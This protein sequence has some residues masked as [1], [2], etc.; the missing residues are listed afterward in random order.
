[1]SRFN[2]PNH[3]V[4]K[5]ALRGYN[6]HMYDVTEALPATVESPDKLGW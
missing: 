4:I 5:N 2:G 1:M 6:C 3:L